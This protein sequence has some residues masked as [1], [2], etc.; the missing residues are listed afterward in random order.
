MTNDLNKYLGIHSLIPSVWN[1]DDLWLPTPNTASGVSI[2]EDEKNIF[3]EVAVPGINPE[4]IDLTVKDNQLW[5]HGEQKEEESDKK[6]KYYRKANNSFSYRITIPS[7]IDQS[8]DPEAS[9]TKGIMTITFSK[10]P[11]A[12]PKKIQVKSK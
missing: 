2:S 11:K 3:I 12:Q 1:D 10:S 5:I 4:N 9:C 8:V 7:D 6:R